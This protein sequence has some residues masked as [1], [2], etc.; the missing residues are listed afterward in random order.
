MLGFAWDAY[1]PTD[2]ASAE[3]QA[4][5]WDVVVIGAGMGGGFAGLSLAQGGKKV[6]FLERG[7]APASSR[8]RTPGR[9][10]R[11][12]SDQHR[13]E[14]LRQRGRWDKRVAVMVDGKRAT[15]QVP[16][17]NGPGGSSAVYGAAVERY[18]RQDF[19]GEHGANAMPGVLPNTWPVG[20]DTFLSSYRAAE[21]ILRPSG[22]RDPCDAD[23][24]ARL[25]P[26]PALSERDEW[27]AERFNAAGLPA[28]RVHVAVDYLPG[29]T[30]CLG[31]LCPRM[32]KSDG[33]S[34]GVIPALVAHG[35]MIALDCEVDRLEMDGPR[36]AG[37]RARQ[38]GRDVMVRATTVILAAG[39]YIS[40]LVLLRSAGPD[41][42]KG[43]G[44]HH[45]LVGRG[46][47]F[48]VDQMFAVWAPR[49]LS[50]SGPVKTFASKQLYVENGK[51]IG[52]LQALSGVVEAG[53][54]EE[55]LR[56][57]LPVLPLA[58]F[59][60]GV[61]FGCR[62]VAMIAARVFAGAVLFSTKTEDFAYAENRVLPDAQSPS[63]FVVQYTFPAELAERAQAIRLA[64]TRKLRAAGVRV[65]FL[66]RMRNLNF[67]H[68]AGTCRMG[69][70]PDQGVVDA[71]GR[72]WGTDNLYI[73]DASVLPTSAAIN[74][75]LT[76]AA[77]AL[78]TA[79]T[80]LRAETGDRC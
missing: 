46:V 13:A 76:V 63:G 16:L 22:T 31:E 74:P 68:A 73:A 60:L 78:R 52:S 29:C 8:G 44:N 65:F 66:S 55:Y 62:M 18:M 21:A 6:L 79:D 59:N 39:A 57:M 53:H 37:V 2:L 64:A 4:I 27:L 5:E 26:P 80:I 41:H 20:Y 61:R 47:M 23:D 34:R 40:P 28:Y 36:V 38:N 32:C 24:D 12:M 25:M 35:A 1:K 48:H 14:A 72:V 54:I 50:T 70:T 11:L 10:A 45:D 56:N 69:T 33:A 49:H 43:V 3:A 42:P 51:R 19:T 30:E 15:V 75:S 17:G 9:I 67:G 58:V 77:C 7:R 71:S